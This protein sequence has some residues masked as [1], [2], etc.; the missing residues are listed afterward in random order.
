MA[1]TR[2]RIASP[3]ALAVFAMLGS[4]GPPPAIGDG[5]GEGPRKGRLD[6]TDPVVCASIVGFRNFEER[7]DA[8]YS[9][10]EKLVIYYEP[11]NFLIV[12]DGPGKPYRAD[13]VQGIRVRRK[14]SDRVLHRI[15]E[16]VEYRPEAPEPPSA[17][18]LSNTISLK[19]LPPGE[20]EVDLVLRDRLAEGEPPAERTVPFRVVPAGQGGEAGR[21][22][23]AGR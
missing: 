14:G 1:W 23:G 9:P 11:I 19:G 5:S 16:M 17:I 8:A 3:I 15:D 6:L 18:F 22:A 2:S 4:I 20:Y 7:D 10:D 21:R 13:L 12:R